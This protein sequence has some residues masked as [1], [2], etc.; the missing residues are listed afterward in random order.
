M[1]SEYK[2]LED[3][4][5][6]KTERKVSRKF[7]RTLTYKICHPIFGRWSKESLYRLEF[8]LILNGGFVNLFLTLW[9]FISGFIIENLI[10]GCL[11]IFAIFFNMA[12]TLLIMHYI[13]NILRPV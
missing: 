3:F 10:S 5:L 6:G 11:V 9:V 13:D 7:R 1:D 4:F 2:E 12:I 8:I